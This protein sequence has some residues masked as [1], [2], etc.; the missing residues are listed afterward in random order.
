MRYVI[1]IGLVL[2]LVVGLVTIKYKQIASLIHM[3]EEME[4]AGPPPETVSS[5]IAKEETWDGTLTS[6]G[7]IAAAKGVAVSTEVPGVVAAI[8]FDSGATVKQ[9]AVLVELDSRVERAQLASIVARRDLAL[10]NVERTRALVASKSVPAAQLDT[11]EAQV[12]AAKADLGALEAQIERKVVRAPFTGRLGL[13]AV[14]VGQYLGPGAVIATLESKDS[15]YVDFSVPQQRASDVK[16]GTKVT[17]TLPAAK[18]VKAGVY[19]G[20]V[21]AVEPSLDAS[22]RT[23][24]L[25]ASV[26]DK[27]DKLRPGMF[28][29]VSIALAAQRGPVVTVPATA[30]VHASYGDSVF[31]V[32]AKKDGAPGAKTAR[33]QIVRVG[34]SRGDFVAIPEGLK[35]G[36]EVVV[37]GAF[38]LRNGAGVVVNNAIKLEPSL[39]PQLENH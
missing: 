30:V 31:V 7:T 21:A 25:R 12:K 15:V 29:N 20:I 18:D 10:L 2:A 28:A 9:G 8:R 27:E 37:A 33:Q 34:E 16:V 1:A 11:D 13:R 3:G 36:Q 32:E 4:K 24:K 17:V 39:V 14:N 19:E 5:T 23:I 35:A 22:T 38:K 6:V 26:P